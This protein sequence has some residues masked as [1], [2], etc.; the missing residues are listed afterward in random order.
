[1]QIDIVNDLTGWADFLAKTNAVTL[2]A[3]ATQ[4][5]A[6]DFR[7]L[8]MRARE[9]VEKERVLVQ[10]EQF[11]RDIDPLGTETRRLAQLAQS[12]AVSGSNVI[13]LRRPAP[14]PNGGGAA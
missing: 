10:Y 9:L 4:Q 5:L 11:A 7:A 14:T 13:P 8:A 1:M 2:S 12:A 3:E 6:K